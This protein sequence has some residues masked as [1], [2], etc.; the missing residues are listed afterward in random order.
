MSDYG[1]H[2]QREHGHPVASFSRS[3][4]SYALA[5]RRTPSQNETGSPFDTSFFHSPRNSA[6]TEVVKDRLII[7]FDTARNAADLAQVVQVIHTE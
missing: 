1:D 3:G 7:V 2:S 6:E 5:A 4:V